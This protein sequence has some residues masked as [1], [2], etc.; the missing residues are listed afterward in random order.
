RPSSPAAGCYHPPRSRRQPTTRLDIRPDTRPA[1]ERRRPRGALGAT[2]A[3]GAPS[4]TAIGLDG[5]MPPEEGPPMVRRLSR[6]SRRDFVRALASVSA[7]ATT[8]PLG[9]GCR[10]D[11]VQRSGSR[12]SAHSP[13]IGYLA[14]GAPPLPLT[15]VFRKA[16]GEYGWIEGE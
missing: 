5:M 3:C 9:V 11:S 15:E 14:T 8:M 13:R 4:L 6:L 2:I 10:M 7:W 1:R 12:G 16:L